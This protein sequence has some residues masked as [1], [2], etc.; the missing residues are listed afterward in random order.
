VPPP[1]PA[2]IGEA[3]WDLLQQML[4][5]APGDRP[6]AAGV[7]VGLAAGQAEPDLEGMRSHA[8]SGE[9][10]QQ[11]AETTA[12]LT[13][14]ATIIRRRSG[15]GVPAATASVAKRHRGVRQLAVVTT[16]A[17]VLLGTLGRLACVPWRPSEGDR[18]RRRLTDQQ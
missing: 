5:K 3:W 8:A 13:G 9:A 16:A 1:R 7:A 14:L 15:G 2:G 10:T 17:A 12:S 6:T 4:A 11:P 18:Q